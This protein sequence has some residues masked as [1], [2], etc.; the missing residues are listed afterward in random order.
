MA[1]ISA[2]PA[3]KASGSS[4][5]TLVERLKARDPEAWRRL[6]V[7]YGPLVYGW[8]RRAGLQE[9]DAADVAQ[10]AFAAVAQHVDGFRRDRPHDS[11]RS[12]LWTI[13]RS[14]LFDHFRRCGQRPEAT[15]GSAAHQQLEQLPDRPPVDEDHRQEMAAVTRRALGIIQTDFQETT[16][17]AFWRTA[18]DDQ[19]AADVAAELGL[20]VAAV[21][22]ARSRVLI[23]LRQELAEAFE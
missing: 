12:W 17:R 1:V 8:A 6:S 7:I 4:S 2:V 23:R 18:I 15:G 11:F 5:A 22:M 9:T 3:S 14:K 16:W 10:E 19:R 20:S 13:T 21:Y